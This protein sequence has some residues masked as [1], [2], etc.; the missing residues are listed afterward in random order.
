MLVD[1]GETFAA[2]AA[3]SEMSEHRSQRRLVEIVG[4]CQRTVKSLPMYWRV[5]VKQ[6]T[7]SFDV[8]MLAQSP[9]E[10]VGKVVNTE[11][12]P[13]LQIAFLGLAIK[14]ADSQSCQGHDSLEAKQK[15]GE[16]NNNVHELK[17]WACF[18]YLKLGNGSPAESKY[19]YFWKC[20]FV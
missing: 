9:K 16:L 18:E 5:P 15:K 2:I 12:Q 7:N 19:E 1:D 17:C 11:N 13:E 14:R 3:W 6:I 8:S 10:Q 4:T 20:C